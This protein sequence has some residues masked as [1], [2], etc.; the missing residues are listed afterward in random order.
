ME[1]KEVETNPTFAGTDADVEDAD[2]HTGV[3][4]KIADI[5]LGAG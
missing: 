1:C 3:P 2:D 5:M 4:D